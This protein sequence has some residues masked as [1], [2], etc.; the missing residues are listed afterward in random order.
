MSVDISDS[1]IAGKLVKTEDTV[2]DNPRTK[3]K[4]GKAKNSDL[5]SGALEQGQWRT[6]FLP[7]LMYWVGN[8]DYGWSIPENEL[9]SAL[10]HIFNAVYGS[11][12]G[13]S[14]FCPDGFA[15]HLVCIVLPFTQLRYSRSFRHPRYAK[16]FTSGALHLV[17][18]LSAF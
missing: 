18:L 13:P 5:P 9:K 7:S 4:K 17:Q 11:R 10:E 16:G 12:R 3:I 8:G 15:F 14:D 1:K 6:S 2:S